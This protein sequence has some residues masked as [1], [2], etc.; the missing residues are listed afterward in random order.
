MLAPIQTPS[1]LAPAPSI[2]GKKSKKKSIKKGKKSHG[3]KKVKNQL[4]FL[5]GGNH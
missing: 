1:V 5:G 2:A 4:N 3:S